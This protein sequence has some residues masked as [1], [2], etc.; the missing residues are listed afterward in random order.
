[1]LCALEVMGLIVVRNGIVRD[2]PTEPPT[3]ARK[4]AEGVG[5]EEEE[6][7]QA[8]KYEPHAKMWRINNVKDTQI[9]DVS[10]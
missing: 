8:Q 1:M 4:E 3:L 9:L 6:V 2:L 7:G 5:E 10:M